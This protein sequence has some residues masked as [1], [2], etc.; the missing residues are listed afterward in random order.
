MKGA[1]MAELGKMDGAISELK[2]AIS[3]A[4]AIQYQPIRWAGRHKLAKLYHQNGLEQ[5]A[6][7]TSSEAEHIIQT[8]ATSFEDENLRVTFLNAALPQ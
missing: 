4:D 3:L 1:A 5:E 6:K 2:T 7:N 8:I